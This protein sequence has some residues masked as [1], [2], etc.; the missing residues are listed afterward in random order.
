[1]SAGADRQTVR[2]PKP[3]SP[4]TVKRRKLANRLRQLRGNRRAAD[5]AKAMGWSEPTFS[6]AETGK[7]GLAVREVRK[8]LDIYEV[9]PEQR[10]ALLILARQAQQIGWWHEYS[11]VLPEDF[12]A[13]A[14]YEDEAAVQYM[15]EPIFV[16]GLFQTDEYA[17]HVLRSNRLEDT[18][19][20]I[21]QRVEARNTR[22]EILKRPKPPRLLVV[23]EE[24]VIRR[25]VGNAQ[26]MRDQLSELIT[27]GQ[28][29]HI[30]IQ[31]V[32]RTAALHAATGAPFIIFEFAEEDMASVVYSEQRHSSLYLEREDIVRSYSL[33]FADAQATA[34]DPQASAALIA[35]Q[36]KELG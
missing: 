19:D 8:L 4:P 34:L 33:A 5:V 10:P 22:K 25:V 26:V 32:P 17:R 27:L 20:E 15:Y 16:P 9:D 30:T 6:R 21:D 23:L 7:K 36:M 1:M 18:D 35:D 14:D 13:F 11:A 31:V 12:G 28:E 24:A 3:P 2:V 29:H